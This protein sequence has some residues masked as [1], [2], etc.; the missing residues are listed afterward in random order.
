LK[1]IFLNFKGKVL[2]KYSDLPGKPV[3]IRMP[4]IPPGGLGLILSTRRDEVVENIFGFGIQ[5]NDTPC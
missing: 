2:K 4:N 5:W 3:L 1:K